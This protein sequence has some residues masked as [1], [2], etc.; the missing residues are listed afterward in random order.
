MKY[1]IDLYESNADYA[2]IAE[3]SEG[4]IKF[5]DVDVNPDEA[6]KIAK[7]IESGKITENEFFDDE[8]KDPDCI[9]S[10]PGGYRHKEYLLTIF[11]KEDEEE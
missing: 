5:V 7:Q 3:N 6:E 1:R 9:N 4:K 10:T 11:D 8:W 2:I